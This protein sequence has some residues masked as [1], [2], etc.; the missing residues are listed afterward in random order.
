MAKFRSKLINMTENTD[1]RDIESIT[2]GILSPEEI[3]AMAV[4]KIDNTK[5]TGPG[6]V[7]DERMGSLTETRD[8]KCVTCGLKSRMCPGHFGYTELVEHIIHPLF[9]KNVSVFLKCFC[10]NCYH[11]IINADQIKLW[12]L[13][14]IKGEG[15]FAR[16]LKKLEKVDICNHCNSPQPKVVFKSKE[17]TIL[18]EYKHKISKNDEGTTGKKVNKISIILTVEEIEKIFN[19]IPDEEVRLLGFDPKLIHPRNMIMSVFPVLPPCARPY[20]MTSG[21]ICDDDL[22][23]Q[24]VEIIKDNIK[25]SKIKDEDDEKTRKKRQKL[26]N[27]SE[28]HIK[29]FCDN[30][31]GKAKHPTD[32][33]PIKGLKE[34]LVSKE[35]QIRQNH[36]GKRVEFSA[37]TVIGPDPTL[38]IGQLAIP[39]EVSKILTFPEK[40]TMFNIEKLTKLVNDNKANF[41]LR[42]D[43]IKKDMKNFN[44]KYAL[45]RRGTEL[46]YGDII[47]RDPEATIYEDDDGKIAV[48]GDSIT[49]VNSGEEQLKSGDRIIRNGKLMD[50]IKLPSRKKFNLKIGDVVERHLQ[51][52]DIVLLNRQP[53]LHKGS[54]L[55]FE[56]VIKPYKTFRINLAT[57]KTFNADFDGDEMNIHA[58]QSYETVAE[59]KMLSAVKHNMISP[60]ESKPNIAI[61]QDSLLSAYRMTKGLVKM[62]RDRF[63]NITL[64]GERVDGSPLWNMDRL[65]NI[66]KVMKMKGKRG[67][68]FTGHGLISLLLPDD[69]YYEKHNKCNPDEPWVRIFQGVMYEGTLNKAILGAAHNSLIHVLHKEYGVDIAANFVD[70]IQFISNE[71]IKYTGFS[72]GLQD[73]MITSIESVATIK[74][75]LAQCY[76]KAQGIEETTQNPGIR[77]IRVT[78][79]LSQAKDI[80]MRI[81]RDAMSDDNNFLDTVGSGSKGDFFNIAQLTGLLGQQNLLGQRV[82]PILNHCKRTLPHY[83]F[84]GLTKEREY[85]SRGFVRHSFIHGLTPHEFFFH[86]MSGREGICDT[87]MS[88]AQSGYVQRRIVKVCEDMETQYDG[89]VRDIVGNI[90]QLS[91]GQNGWD[92]SRTMKVKGEQEVCDVERL[93][94]KLNYEFER[95]Q[96]T[97]LPTKK[98]KRKVKNK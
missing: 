95:K 58:P 13:G 22:T 24:I 37:R 32:N 64:K 3:K 35:G 33:Q 27:S 18:L 77:E 60:Q 26:I 39:V 16:I 59:L 45:F 2:F 5:L 25:L 48:E 91:Y 11:L 41:V 10:K 70:N 61:V 62:S 43:D 52:G 9:I 12:G 90:Y 1:A 42:W 66:K 85:E 20:I 30:S 96:E 40:V 44:L 8:S 76:T 89:S 73:C 97:Q 36:M 75:T 28:F 71:W 21:N 7:Y 92:P 68:V 54:M 51:D 80:G 84:T 46:L 17:K 38:K 69:F 31:K 4:C 29:T 79:T 23:T 67:R 53:T 94:N 87:A 47:V 49:V 74:K 50:E 65:H 88:T 34:R 15:K 93:I 78:A 63:Y 81:A 14:K 57:T 55:A 6:T 98:K 72:M 56:I 86:A 83:P 82:K 19:N